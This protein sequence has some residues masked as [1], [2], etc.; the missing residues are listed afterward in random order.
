MHWFPTAAMS[1][2]GDPLD[3]WVEKFDS[4]LGAIPDIENWKRGESEWKRRAR[5]FDE[6]L[7]GLT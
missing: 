6:R 1:V 5:V 3:L 7:E 2:G 4:L